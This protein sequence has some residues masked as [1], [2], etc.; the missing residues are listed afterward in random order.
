[1][2]TVPPAIRDLARRLIAAEAARESPPGR[3]GGSAGRVC[4]GLRVSL[5]RLA[6]AAGFHSLACRAVALAAAEVVTFHPPPVREDGS[7]EWA[8]DAGPAGEGGAAV[9]AHLLGLLAA[10]VGESLTRQLVSDVWPD[11]D[12]PEVDGPGGRAGGRL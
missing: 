2:T 11:I 3:P 6:G 8:A 12:G 10:L 4:E 5:I 7:L 9:V 1:M